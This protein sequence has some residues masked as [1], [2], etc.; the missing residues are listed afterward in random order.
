MF[1]WL[2]AP[3]CLVAVAFIMRGWPTFKIGERHY[4]YYNEDS[5][6]IKD[7]KKENEKT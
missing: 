4:H 7:E 2:T 6:D 1:D 3:L 5:P